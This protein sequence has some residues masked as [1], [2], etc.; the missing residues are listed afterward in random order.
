MTSS[1]S[2]RDGG[3]SDKKKSSESPT[4]SKNSE[5]RIQS[6]RSGQKR[7]VTDNEWDRLF[8]R[9]RDVAFLGLGLAAA[10][11]QLSIAQPPNPVLYPI[12]AALLEAPS[13]FAL[14]DRRKDNRDEQEKE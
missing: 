13:A 9:V 11:H 4:N 8:D 10:T 6:K 14:D 3:S 12:I 2:T 5:H 7:R 1:E